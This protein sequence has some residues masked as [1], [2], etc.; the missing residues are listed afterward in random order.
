[1]MGEAKLFPRA[2]H[3]RTD[4]QY[5]IFDGDAKFGAAVLDFQESCGISP[6]RASKHRAAHAP[7]TNMFPLTRNGLRAGEIR[8]FVLL[9]RIE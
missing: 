6:A 1:L 7:R 3:D 8:V 2:F 9:R 5:L 4:N